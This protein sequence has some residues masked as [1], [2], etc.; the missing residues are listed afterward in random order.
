MSK[1]RDQLFRRLSYIQEM[2][3][4]I[5]ML[6]VIVVGPAGLSTEV[7]EIRARLVLLRNDQIRKAH[8]NM[9]PAPTP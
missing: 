8:E 9:P 7:A 4:R 6:D 1:L 3:D 2:E 5:E